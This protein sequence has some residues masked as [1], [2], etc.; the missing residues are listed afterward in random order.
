MTA[1][2]RDRVRGKRGTL[3]R[4]S[5]ARRIL[6]WLSVILGTLIVLCTVAYYRLLAHLQSEDFCKTLSKEAQAALQ[7]DDVTL[8]DHLQIDGN[9]VSLG[10]LSVLNADI[11]SQLTSRGISMEINRGA[12]WNRCL[13]LRKLTV[14][15]AALHITLPRTKA[16][17]AATAKNATKQA[18]A[19]G[20]KPAEAPQAEQSSSGWI[21]NSFDLAAFECKDVDT[22]LQIDDD[23]YA[24]LGCNTSA[25]PHKKLGNNTWQINLENGRLHTSLKTLRDSSVKNA[26]IIASPREISLTESRVLL[27][28]GELRARGSYNVAAKRWSAV[29]RSNKANVARILNDTWAKR[30]H[31][32]LYGELE[33]A[34][35][36]DSLKRGTGYLS[37]QK[38]ILEGLPILSDLQFGNT[39]PYRAI[40]LEKAECRLRYPYNDTGRNIRNAWVFDQI[41]IRSHNGL[42]LVRGHVIIGTDQSLGGTLHIGLPEN[43]FNELQFKLITGLFSKKDEQG[44]IWFNLNLSGNLSDPQEDLSIRLA[45]ILGQTIPE[46]SADAAQT[47]GNLFNNI[48][49]KPADSPKNTPQQT[50]KETPAPA[51]SPIKETGNFLKNTLH[52][53]F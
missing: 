43:R 51:K 21:P 17:A 36:K 1:R 25:A 27:T 10:E 3:A 31:G 15:E 22:H 13:S 35:T 26:T 39:R 30:L 12:L 37:L 7:A 24:L 47:I 6:I 23:T 11:L 19:D 53:F 20:T 4:G 5:R 34:G 45:T 33:L 28:P 49:T 40:S 18:L 32:E 46:L 52:S 41:D 44:Y 50:E 8:R 48:F 29:I 38:G 14:E 16:T 2:R 42:L 9:R